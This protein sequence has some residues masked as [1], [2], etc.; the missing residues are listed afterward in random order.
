MVRGMKKLLS[1]AVLLS[2][3][4]GCAARE[5]PVDFAR[6]W[7]LSISSGDSSAEE[8][9]D[10]ESFIALGYPVGMDYLAM[11]NEEEKALYRTGF[12]S[13]YAANFQKSGGS[14]DA[15]T[16]WTVEFDDSAR[17]V[18]SATPP[19]GV[20]YGYKKL[21]ITVSKRDGGQK[22]SAMAVEQ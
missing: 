21:T 4:I 8:L 13:Q 20:G 2:S 9:I 18:V 11:P 22:I 5:D 17:T 7:F 6:G 15:F 19:S 1:I 16:D 10:W 3:L 14:A 12:V